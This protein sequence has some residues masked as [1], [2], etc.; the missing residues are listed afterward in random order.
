MAEILDDMDRYRQP[1][2]LGGETIVE[3]L[4]MTRREREQQ[5]SDA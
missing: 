3:S 2:A 1:V 5:L 4:D